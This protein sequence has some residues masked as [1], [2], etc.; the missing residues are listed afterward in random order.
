MYMYEESTHLRWLV[1]QVLYFMATYCL[2]PLL[3]SVH[4]C[5]ELACCASASACACAC[6]GAGAGASAVQV[7]LQVMCGVSACK[8]CKFFHVS[9]A[10]FIKVIFGRQ[11]LCTLLGLST[12]GFLRVTSYVVGFFPPF[13]IFSPKNMFSQKNVFFKKKH[14][15]I[16]THVFTKKIDQ[17]GYK[18]QQSKK[19][20]SWF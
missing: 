12:I 18:N 15:F 4:G 8:R 17:M 5:C 3:V 16:K 6:A 2:L 10:T 20:M 1:V 7:Q 9:I 19:G 11:L 14:V 13:F